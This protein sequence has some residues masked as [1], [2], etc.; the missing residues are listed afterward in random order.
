M[1]KLSLGGLLLSLLVLSGCSLNP[2]KLGSTS[3]SQDGSR[4]PFQAST[5][6]GALW[7]SIDG[8]QTFEPKIT[9]DE[10]RR[11]TSAN[12]LDISFLL[13]D[14]NGNPTP[15][16]APS[17][18]VGTVDNGIFKSDD[19]A[20]TWQPRDFP[21]KKVYRFLADAVNPERLYATG[22]VNGFGKVFRTTDGGTTWQDVYTEPGAGTVLLSLVQSRRHPD[23]LFVGTSAGTVIRTLDGGSTWKNVGSGLDGP[24]TEIAFDAVLPDRLYALAHEKKVYRSD[25]GGLTWFD[26]LTVAKSAVPTSP[27][28][29]TPT[30][31]LVLVADPSRSNVVY[32]GTKAGL[33]RSTT[34][35][36]DWDKVNII[37]SA[38]K[39]PLRALAVNPRNSDEIVFVAGH[40]FYKSVNNGDTWSVVPLDVDREVSALAYD[41]FDSRILYLGLRK[42]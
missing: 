11:I 4:N 24:I 28:K 31:M 6:P 35:G 19:G 36:A 23:T 8:G 21:P 15:S 37:E 29:K 13:R 33:F 41:P 25:D 40:T 12:I 14:P 32:L 9:V 1:Q 7:R 26:P 10:K 38:E 42:F 17:I 2:P 39:F 16:R 20:E 30:G 27:T 22:V 3:S 34:G 18:F 5:R